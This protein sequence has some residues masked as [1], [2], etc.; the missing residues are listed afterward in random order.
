LLP[1]EAKGVLGGKL[2]AL[3]EVHVVSS[4]SVAAFVSPEVPRLAVPEERTKA[5]KERNFESGSPQT[6]SLPAC[7]PTRAEDEESA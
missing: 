7:L 1:R 5:G 3:P 6:E 2:V 4:A